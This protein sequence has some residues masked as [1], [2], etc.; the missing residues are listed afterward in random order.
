MAKRVKK[1]VRLLALI[2]AVVYVRKVGIDEV[3]NNA[4]I[5]AA[6]RYAQLRRLISR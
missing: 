5:F 1:I 6:Q 3:R 4:I 2:A